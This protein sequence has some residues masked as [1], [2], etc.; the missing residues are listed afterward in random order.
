MWTSS[1]FLYGRSIGKHWVRKMWVKMKFS[2]T[3]SDGGSVMET[4]RKQAFILRG[5]PIEFFT[6]VIPT[7]NF[8]QFRNPEGYFSHPTSRAYFQS[9]ISLWFCVIVPNPELQMREITY[10]ENLLR[11]LFLAW[12]PAKNLA[13][14]KKFFFVSKLIS[15]FFLELIRWISHFQHAQ[16]YNWL[17]MCFVR[18]W[19]VHLIHTVKLHRLAWI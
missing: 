16:V 14:V 6:P 13:G 15:S 18:V 17:F 4:R 5:S 8:M 2:K 9:Q 10:P 3:A 19:L 1:V 7:Q 11:T 12:Q